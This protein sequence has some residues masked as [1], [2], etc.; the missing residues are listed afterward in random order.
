LERT[1][2]KLLANQ[3]PTIYLG[4]GDLNISSDTYNISGQPALSA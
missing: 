1:V 3:K 4:D 2:D